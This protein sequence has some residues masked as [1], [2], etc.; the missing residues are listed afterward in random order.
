MSVFD[1]N[2]TSKSA[3]FYIV[4]ALGSPLTGL[5]YNSAGASAYYTRSGAAA[6]AITLAT[7]AS[8]SAAWSSGGFKEVDATNAPG[9][10]RL[11]LPNAALASGVDEVFISLK[12]TGVNVQPLKIRL[13]AKTL[14]AIADA[15]FKRDLTAVTGAAML[16]LRTV[17]ARFISRSKADIGS[18]ELVVYDFDGT[19]KIMEQD[20]VF[21]G[22]GKI[23]DLSVGRTPN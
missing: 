23:T 3:Y 12:F 22:T 21:D 9:L 20:A 17:M 6:V 4:D 13:E 2:L 1:I 16:S 15:I 11:D 5:A 14:T 10:Y 7:L 19:T 18:N 8:A